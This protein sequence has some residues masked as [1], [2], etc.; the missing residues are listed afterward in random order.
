M[1]PDLD[2]KKF[3]VRIEHCDADLTGFE[4]ATYA[5]LK[6]PVLRSRPKMAAPGNSGAKKLVTS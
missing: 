5:T 4:L 1:N 2:E 6:Q 3:R